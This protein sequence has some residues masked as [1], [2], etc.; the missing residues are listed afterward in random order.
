M[1]RKR[2][3]HGRLCYELVELTLNKKGLQF[4]NPFLFLIY[5]TQQNNTMSCAVNILKNIAKG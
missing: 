5:Y 2:L 3:T 4:R 1:L